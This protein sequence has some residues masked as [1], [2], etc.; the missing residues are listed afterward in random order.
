MIKLQLRAWRPFLHRCPGLAGSGSTPAE[1]MVAPIT[2]GERAALRD[3]LLCERRVMARQLA[4]LERSFED[5]VEACELQPPDDE[6]DPD[7]TTAYD[8]AQ[9]TSLTTAARARLEGVERALAA[10]GEHDFGSCHGC[11]QSIGV[12]RLQVL[13]GVRNCV[14]CAAAGRTGPESP[15]PEG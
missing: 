6:H 4:G 9:V 12:A 13:P 1:L 14:A 7:A 8:R 5:L 15:G 10:V 11:G 3:Q 2:D